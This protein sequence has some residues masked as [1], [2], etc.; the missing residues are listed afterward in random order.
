MQPRRIAR[1]LAL[2][3]LSQLPSSQEKLETQQL[4]NMVLAAVRTL[5]TEVQDTLTTAAAELQRASDRLLSSETRAGDLRTSRS[6]LDESIQ[7][8]QSAINRVGAALEI[9]ELI[10]LANQPDFDVRTYALQIVRAV[11]IHRTEI[12]E[13]LNDAL[14]DWQVSRLARIDRDLLRIAV[15]EILYLGVP[16]RVAINEAVELAKRY[17]GDE[18]HRFINGVLRRISEQAQATY[19]KS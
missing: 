1:E 6:L 8:T 5:T 15:A 3:S 19:P 7:L 10:Q 2:L 11:N 9:P 12:D 14:V 18:G 17:S 4:S 13:K 16:D